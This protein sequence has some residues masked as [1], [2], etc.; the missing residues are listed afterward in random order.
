MGA[1]PYC[2]PSS[3]ISIIVLWD[4]SILEGENHVNIHGISDG[5]VRAIIGF[6]VNQDSHVLR[7][8]NIT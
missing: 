1:L 5:E 6:S 2:S 8:G 3:S 7:R 4:I